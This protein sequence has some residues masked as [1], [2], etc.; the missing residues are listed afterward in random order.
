MSESGTPRRNRN[1]KPRSWRGF[2]IVMR[3]TDRLASLSSVLPFPAKVTIVVSLL[4][5]HA[6]PQPVEHMRRGEYV[7]IG[8]TA[9]DHGEVAFDIVAAPIAARY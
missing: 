9:L 5:R 8:K 6:A 3:D 1:E 7:R 2:P 4:R